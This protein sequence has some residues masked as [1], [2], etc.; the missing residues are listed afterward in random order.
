[1]ADGA[2]M[3]PP[4]SSYRLAGERTP[5]Y[6]TREVGA[7]ELCVSLGTWDTWAADGTLPPIAPGFPASCPRWRWVDVD[8]RLA[9]RAEAM[10]DRGVA[11]AANLRQ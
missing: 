6:V 1:M 4:K 5:A 10:Q 7:A 9:G 2:A 11:R 8:A 3:S